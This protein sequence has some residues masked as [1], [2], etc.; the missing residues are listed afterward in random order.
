LIRELCFK[1][2]YRAARFFFVLH[3][4]QH[5]L[6]SCFVEADGWRIQSLHVFA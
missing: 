1:Q 6:P 5:T 3:V 4:T 2:R